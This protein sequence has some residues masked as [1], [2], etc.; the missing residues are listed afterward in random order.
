MI[1]ISSGYNYSETIKVYN[2]SETDNILHVTPNPVSKEL[3]LSTSFPASGPVTIRI[4]DV[5]GKV[6]K[7]ISDNVTA[8]Y[9]TIPINQLEKLASGTYFIEVKQKDYIRNTKF[10]KIN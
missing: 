8:G 2:R 1:Y 9:T 4:T 6:V 10:V 5:N 3:T 7:Q